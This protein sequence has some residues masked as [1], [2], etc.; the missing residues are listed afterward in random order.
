LT[1]EIVARMLR[2]LRDG[3]CPRVLGVIFLLKKGISPGSSLAVRLTVRPRQPIVSGLPSVVIGVQKASVDPLAVLSGVF[4]G[5]SG[6]TIWSA[7]AG[8]V[9]IG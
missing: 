8:T 4:D 2:Q 3:C 9:V 6:V 7:T 5:T 1:E